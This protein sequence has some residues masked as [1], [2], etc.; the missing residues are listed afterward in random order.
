MNWR[1]AILFTLFSVALLATGCY[2]WYSDA[3]RTGLAASAASPAPATDAPPAPTP[4][5]VDPPPVKKVNPVKVLC[6]CTDC[7]CEEGNPCGCV[8]VCKCPDCPGQ[9]AKLHAGKTI[10]VSPDGTVNEL[11]PDGIY[12]PIPG[13]PKQKVKAAA[14]PPAPFFPA[15]VGGR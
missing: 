2:Y 12:R 7:R 4:A 6:E 9:I 8:G 14:V 10:H 3:Q 5:K 1:R 11:H 15:C 13:A